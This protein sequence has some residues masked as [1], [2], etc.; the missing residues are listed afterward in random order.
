MVGRGKGGKGGKG[1]AVR[2]WKL[3]PNNI[4]EIKIT[5]IF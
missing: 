5:K 4:T 1:G 2:G 3:T